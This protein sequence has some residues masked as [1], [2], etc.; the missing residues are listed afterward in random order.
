[1]K[2]FIIIAVS[3]IMTMGSVFAQNQFFPSKEG[4]VLLYANIDAKGKVD[5][6]SRLTIRKVEG[7]GDNLSVSYVGQSLDKNRKPASELE[8]PFTVTIVNGVV[9]W[10]MKSFVS[11]APGTEGFIEIEGDKIRIPSTLSQGDKLD[12]V[13]F[14]MTMNMG[15]RIRT[16]ISLTEQE[17]LAIEDVTV[18]A[19]TFK[20]HKLTQTSAATVMRRTTTTKTISWY[21]PDIGTVKTEVYDDKNRLQSSTELQ[22]IE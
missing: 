3:V 18:P 4:L 15:I 11:I 16:E 21:A 7:S 13:K 10:D 2:R 6:Y 5:S 19:G 20:C 17:C 22:S 1:M 9:E 8:V 12:D 14:T